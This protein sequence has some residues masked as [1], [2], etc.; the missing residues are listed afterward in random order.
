MRGVVERARGV[1]MQSASVGGLMCGR[2][3]TCE[4][5]VTLCGLVCSV[6]IR[7]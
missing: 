1:R 5:C 3:G 6:R 2:E 4:V 7:G